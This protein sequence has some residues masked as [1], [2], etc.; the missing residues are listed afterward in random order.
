MIFENLKSVLSFFSSSSSSLPHLSS[1]LSQSSKSIARIPHR[2]YNRS[3]GATRTR[4]LIYRNRVGDTSPPILFSQIGEKFIQDLQS[5]PDQ[6][7]YILQYK[8]S[9]HKYFPSNFFLEALKYCHITDDFGLES[10][11]MNY[12][13]EL[14]EK[15]LQEMVRRKIPVE[16]KHFYEIALLRG[17]QEFP[18]SEIPAFV[19]HVKQNYG[20]E[21]NRAWF[22]LLFRGYLTQKNHQLCF[23]LFPFYYQQKFKISTRLCK[24]MTIAFSLQ[25]NRCKSFD[26]DPAFL[27]NLT[28]PKKPYS[29]NR[30]FFQMFLEYIVHNHYNDYIYPVWEKYYHFFL[31]N[32]AILALLLEGFQR[33]P[34]RF[35]AELAALQELK[36]AYDERFGGRSRE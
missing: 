25:E 26:V 5:L 3:S 4:K 28:L 16:Q 27:Q 29:F 15:V 13:A 36:V 9:I 22:H 12:R 18:A 14:S 24:I 20:L 34:H 11:D 19:A 6:P 23:E 32:E 8:S 21:L 2:N 33:D 1:T 30:D 31:P 7:C 17:F 10:K 35:A